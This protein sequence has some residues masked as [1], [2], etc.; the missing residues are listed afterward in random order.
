MST[1]PETTENPL[2]IL[3]IEDDAKDLELAE[4][5]LHHEWVSFLSRCEKDAAGFA[6]ALKE[7][8][9]DVV[10]S[11]YSMPEFDGLSA[12][13]LCRETLPDVPFILHSGVL[14]DEAAVLCL[15]AGADD[16][17]L[18]Q[19]IAHLP[20]AVRNAFERRTA[21]KARRT[22]E[23]KLAL[24]SRAV[25]Q[26]P[27]SVVITDTSGNIEYVNPKFVALTGYTSEEV[28]G[29]NPRVLKSGKQPREFYEDL[30]KTLS[31]G[32][33]WRG[34]FENKKKNGEHYC[35]LASISPVRDE[36]GTVTHFLAIK[37]DI[38]ARKTAEEHAQRESAFLN[39]LIRTIPDKILFEDLQCRIFKLNAAAVRSFG[40]RDQQEV[41]GH[42]IADFFP[43]EFVAKALADDRRVM[44]T[45]CIQT[46]LEEC[47]TLPDGTALCLSTSKVPLRDNEGKIIGLIGVSR[48]ITNLKNTEKRL[49]ELNRQLKSALEHTEELA[50]KAEA[51]SRAKS[52]FLAIMSHELRTPLNGVLGF[53][54]LLSLTK[55][56][57]EQASFVQTITLS[58]NHLLSV[59]SDI[60]DFS[61]IEKRHLTIQSA[62][63]DLTGI[64]ESSVLAVR[65]AAMAKGLRF[66]CEVAPDV[67]EQIVG[68]ERRIRQILIN[69]LGNAVKFTTSGSIS[70]HVANSFAGDRPALDFSVTDDGIGI[71][72][73]TIKRLFQPFMQGD[74]TMQ[75]QFGG[76]GLGLAISHRLAEAMGGSITVVSAPGQGS[77]FTFQLPLGIPT[78]PDD[79][80]S[81]PG[82]APPNPPSVAERNIQIAD[83]SPI[84]PKAGLVLVVEDDPDN[85]LLAGKML[86]SLGYRP[87]FATNGAEAVAAFA[88]GK[89]VAILMDVLL[90]MMDGLD[91]TRQIRASEFGSR[92]PIIALT[93]NVMS[94]D[95]E[96]CLAAGMDDFL[97]KPF[98]RAELAAKLASVEHT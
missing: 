37:E 25:E 18:K 69:L 68:D 81:A 36:H 51:A 17:V 20:F 65:Q 59:V 49:R 23:E 44:E 26:S 21:Q 62:P 98:K 61:S 94:G 77:T 63:A 24:L 90:P 11:D 12:L 47:M 92:V 13:K 73:E 70:L 35:E 56:D 45:G 48:D 19:N 88:P 57:E 46:G 83:D 15:R 43:A 75:R 86:Q 91:A 10:I 54:E 60:L 3:F 9:P 95:R 42:T 8:V 76:T 97:A 16:Y 1:P 84:P 64:V 28:I 33:D 79:P 74:S 30:W 4:W 40:C 27:A 55:L 53:A 22:A 71:S 72:P 7:F 67:P 87:E 66:R 80:A 39:Q 52:E 5:H 29:Q 85:S 32:Y 2:R 93:A 82:E 96:R 34:E 41:I 14:N 6:R 89:Y 58:G 31:S 78:T 38:T 50:E